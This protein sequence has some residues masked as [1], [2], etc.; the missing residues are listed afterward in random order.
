MI[1]TYLHPT[2]MHHNTLQ[3]SHLSCANLNSLIVSH[4]YSWLQHN[5]WEAM[6]MEELIPY[7]LDMHEIGHVCL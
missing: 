5:V 1:G 7:A 2:C 6:D 4:C 3:I